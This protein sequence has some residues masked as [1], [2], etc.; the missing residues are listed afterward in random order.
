MIFT[1]TQEQADQINRGRMA[2]DSIANRLQSGTWPEGAQAH[3]GN[4]AYVGRE[5][6]LIVVRVWPDEHG[7]GT[8]GVNG[9]VILDGN[10]SLWITSAKYGMEEGQWRWPE[11]V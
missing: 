11:R 8:F 5:Y 10:D 2:G 4:T 1:I 9:Q 6:P 3:I 7:P